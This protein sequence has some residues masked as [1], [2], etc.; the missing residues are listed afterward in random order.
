MLESPS[1]VQE[2][3]EVCVVNTGKIRNTAG[4]LLDGQTVSL[5]KFEISLINSAVNGK[6]GS[7]R[8]FSGPESA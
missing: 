2:A 4:W 7:S 6:S 5:A 1:E 8:R 3:I